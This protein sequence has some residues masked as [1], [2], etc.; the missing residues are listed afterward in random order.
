MSANSTAIDLSQLPLPDIIEQL[1]FEAIFAQMVATV[2][3][4][5]PGLFDGIPDFD[6]TIESDPAVKV[7]QTAAYYRMLDRQRVNDAVKAVLLAYARGDDLTNLGAFFNVARLP[8]ET[9]DAYLQRVQLAPD[10]YS[11][12]GPS[13]AYEYLARSAAPGIKDAR[14]T[15]PSP[16]QVLVSIL[17]TA[18][19]G[20]PTADMIA[21]AQ[22][23]LTPADARPLTDHP[24][25]QAARIIAYAIEADLYT[26]DGPDPAVVLATAQ[27]AVTAK[28]EALRLLGYDVTRSAL[29]AALHVAGVQRVVLNSPAADIACDDTQS[30]FCTG[31]TVNNAGI[32]Q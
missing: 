1:S 19:D 25:A 21:A 12:A 31:I 8:G 16:G 28:A 5:A 30:T 13:G 26:Y 15:S 17:A 10:G 29:S 18:G 6:G 14:A 9:D 23:A 22:A 24:T 32:A 3:A 7:L 2:Q 20:T 11:V 4:G 27:T